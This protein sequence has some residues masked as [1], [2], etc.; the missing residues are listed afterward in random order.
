MD[1]L[2]N[3]PMDAQRL[4]PD[5]DNGLAK[6]PKCP[7]L[8]RSNAAGKRDPALLGGAIPGWVAFNNRVQVG[9]VSSGVGGSWL[10][11]MR[12]GN[13]F[14]NIRRMRSRGTF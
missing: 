13:E 7:S 5:W 9:S 3:A 8:R 11:R 14:A 12:A 4:T 10:A 6:A 1:I 2:V